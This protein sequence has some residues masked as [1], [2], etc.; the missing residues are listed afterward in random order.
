MSDIVGI[1]RGANIKLQFKFPVGTD[2]TGATAWFSAAWPGGSMRRTDL[3]L[4]VPGRSFTLS[5]TP[6]ET[7]A[8]PEGRLTSYELELRQSGNQTIVDSG[9]IE[10][11][12][13]LNDD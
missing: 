2:L 9:K 7:R 13:G 1:W 6:A 12:G 3:V 10:A 11:V 5:L 8:L 4:N